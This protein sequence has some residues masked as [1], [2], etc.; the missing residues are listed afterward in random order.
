MG[1]VRVRFALSR[2]SLLTLIALECLPAKFSD[3]EC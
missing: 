2:E 3:G 1:C